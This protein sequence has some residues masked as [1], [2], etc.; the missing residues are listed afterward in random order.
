MPPFRVLGDARRELLEAAHWYKEEGG[1]ALARAFGAAYRTQ[2]VRARTLPLSGHSI[3]PMPR[4]VTL[5]LRSFLLAN[6][7]YRVVV[8]AQPSEIIVVAVA[9]QRRRPFYWADRLDDT[10]G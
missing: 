10:E 9:H 3:G 1:L 5:D 8:A 6:F 2:L 4:E 7:P